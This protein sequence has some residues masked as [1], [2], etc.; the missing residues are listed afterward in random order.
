MGKKF[1]FSPNILLTLQQK[2]YY[3]N[4]CLF[5][6][7]NFAVSV[8]WAGWIHDVYTAGGINFH[9]QSCT[10]GCSLDGAIHLF[11]QMCQDSFTGIRSTA[12]NHILLKDQ[13]L[14]NLTQLLRKHFAVVEGHV[15]PHIVKEHFAFF[16]V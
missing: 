2:Q 9:R 5:L 10:V 1:P 12:T 14:R 8:K 15:L 4:M 7:P 16:F 6:T 13:A 11:H 3:C